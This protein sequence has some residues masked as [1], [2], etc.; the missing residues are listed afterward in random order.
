MCLQTLRMVESLG[1][2][3]DQEVDVP[4]SHYEQEGSSTPPKPLRVLGI[5]SRTRMDWRLLDFAGKGLGF[6][7]GFPLHFDLAGK[8]EAWE[9]RGTVTIPLAP[10]DGGKGYGE[11]PV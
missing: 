5:W 2:A 10:F 6:V 3:L 9:R 1:R 8:L 4:V 7:L 11:S